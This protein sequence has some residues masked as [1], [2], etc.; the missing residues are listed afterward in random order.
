MVNLHH[1]VEQGESKRFRGEG[2]GTGH[3]R[4]DAYRSDSSL[5]H[6]DS[7]D[8]ACSLGRDESFAHIVQYTVADALARRSETAAAR[9]AKADDVVAMKLHQVL[10]MEPLLI[11]S[12]R[13]EDRLAEAAG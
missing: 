11:G 8:L 9:A 13:I 5:C 7:V 12:V 10:R 1:A 2:E 3:R 4:H 6:L